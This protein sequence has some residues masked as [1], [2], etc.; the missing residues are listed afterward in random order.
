MKYE[1][2]GL[3][4]L[5]N[6]LTLIEH[7]LGPVKEAALKDGGKIMQKEAERIA[8]KRT[9]NLRE[10][11]ELSGVEDNSIYVYVDNQGKAYYGH[12]L[13][14]GTSKMSARP[15]MGPAFNR[16]K[17]QVNQAMANKIR[18]FMRLTT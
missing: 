10:N 11:I 12:M 3:T 16:S 17:L 5:M 8:R 14:F 9:G 15:F 2:K 7:G 1:M 13:E 4:E 6:Q 18:Q